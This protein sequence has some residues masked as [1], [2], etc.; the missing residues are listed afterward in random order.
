VKE[1][2]NVKNIEDKESILW[3]ESQQKQLTFQDGLDLLKDSLKSNNDGVNTVLNT[4]TR[5]LD[6]SDFKM[7]NI[8]RGLEGMHV[9]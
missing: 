4:L 2:N 9:Q 6:E 8:M 1:N 7:A 5:R 3:K